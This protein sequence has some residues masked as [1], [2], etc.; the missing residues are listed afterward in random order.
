MHLFSERGERYG[1]GMV[2]TWPWVRKQV[3]KVPE[4]LHGGSVVINPTRIHEDEGLIPG[5][6]QWVKGPVAVS[7]GVG[8]RCGSDLV[9]WLWC[10]LAATSPI[11]PLAWEPPYATGEALK[12]QK[13]VPEQKLPKEVQVRLSV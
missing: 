11:Q 9:L 2:V 10:R 7:C 3:K 8:H 4:D 12:R 6:A 5:L 1:G 13:K